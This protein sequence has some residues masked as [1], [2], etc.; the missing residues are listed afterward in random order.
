MDLP[1]TRRWIE[2]IHEIEDGRRPQAIANLDELKA[3]FL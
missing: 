2:M 3:E 1:L